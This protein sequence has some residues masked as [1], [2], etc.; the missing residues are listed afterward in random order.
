MSFE[1]LINQDNCNV[2]IYRNYFTSEVQK[3]LYDICQREC[4]DRFPVVVYGRES[5]QPRNS[6][7]FADSN[8]KGQ[9]YS[10]KIIKASPWIPELENLRNFLAQYLCVPGTVYFNSVLIN[11]YVREDDNVGFHR[12]KEMID[13]LQMVVT[14]SLGDSR[15]F[16]FRKYNDHSV[17]VETILNSGDL[18]IMCGD[19]NKI[20]EHS[21]PKPRK[22]ESKFPRYSLTF[23][24][25]SDVL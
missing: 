9:K 16:I 4:V 11:G 7:V 18:L 20:W 14:I 19:T 22:N 21:I 13:P 17:K 24:C 25:I 10:N 3:S 5:L 6:K 1:K 23:R 8:I 15:R 12:D 2:D